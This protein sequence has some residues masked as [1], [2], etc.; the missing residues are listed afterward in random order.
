MSLPRLL[1]HAI[2]KPNFQTVPDYLNFCARYLEFIGNENN[3]Q[4]EIVSQ[5]ERWYRFYQYLEDGN[6]NVT[7]PINSDLMYQSESFA[8]AAPL[9]EEVL[10]GLRAGERPGDEYRQVVT[11]VIY[12]VQ[13][14]IGATL[15]A[16]PAGES[17]KARKINGDLFERFIQVLIRRLGIDCTAGVIQVPIKDAAGEVVHKMT[18]QHDLMIRSEMKLKVI[19]SVKTSS[20]DRIDKIFM[21]KFFYSKITE[22]ALPHIAIFLNDVQRKRSGRENRYGVNATFLSGHFK[23]YTIVL[24]ALDGV[25][26]CD[27]RPNMV[28]DPFLSQHIKTI[29]HL[30]YNDLWS[31]IAVEG[32]SLDEVVIAE[33][34]PDDDS[35]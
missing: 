22:T 21:D 4:A 28:N 15:D 30:F 10:D 16:L 5:N 1:A 7:R 6:Y 25:Y 2:H 18:Y 33:E 27:I 3:Y 12:T 14:S 32:L 29:D 26:Y 11:R 20:K 17:N 8:V 23:A 24:N 13:Q 9:F 19:G 35:D 34:D 31:L